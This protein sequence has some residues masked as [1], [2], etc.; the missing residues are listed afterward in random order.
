MGR[1]RG[2]IMRE[3]ENRGEGRRGSG[4]LRLV[5]LAAGIVATGVVIALSFALPA[6]AHRPT[7]QART[8]IYEDTHYP[9]AERAADLV[10][11]LTPTQR[12]SQLASSQAPAITTAA[13]PLLT[14]TFG[15]QTAL[16]AP[17]SAG[18]TNLKV[19][20]TGGLA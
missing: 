7:H 9:S 1:R 6:G 18:A 10:P 8:P 19:E 20:S 12:A 16:A 15:G 2:G 5:P 14:D 3:V 13:N 4:R 17:A 11:R